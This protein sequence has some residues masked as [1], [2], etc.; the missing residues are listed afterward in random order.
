M[1]PKPVN[2]HIVQTRAKKS[3]SY[4]MSVKFFIKWHQALKQLSDTFLASTKWKGYFRILLFVCLLCCKHSHYP[5]TPLSHTTP[6]TNEGQY[7][8]G[9]IESN[10]YQDL[11]VFEKPCTCCSKQCLWSK[12]L[13]K[14]IWFLT[15]SL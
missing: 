12:F 15:G 4:C 10:N 8:Q 13:Y 3:Q 9:S 11:D 6:F 2:D 7:I 14:Q 1:I 5:Q